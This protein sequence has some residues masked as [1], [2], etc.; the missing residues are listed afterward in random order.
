[1]VIKTM[2]LYSSLIGSERVKILVAK[3]G[4]VMFLFDVHAVVVVN[5]VT[6]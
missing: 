4:T 5:H 6:G 2:C 3:R 1:M